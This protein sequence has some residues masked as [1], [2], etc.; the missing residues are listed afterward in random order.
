MKTLIACMVLAIGMSC[1]S[2][3]DRTTA[4]M[5][6]I[7]TN[8]SNLDIAMIFN[9]PS[10]VMSE[11]YELTLKLNQVDNDVYALEVS[12]LLNNDSQFVS[13]NSKRGFKG[14]FSIQIDDSNNLELVSDL[15]ETPLSVEEYDSHPFVDGFVNWVREDTRYNQKIKRT[16]E[17]K[18]HVMGMI[19]FVIE[20]RCTFEKI[21]III[22]YENGEMRVEIFQC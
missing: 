15:I 20:P 17:D 5:S 18:F 7:E 22:K 16:S 14:K 11:P 6:T 1:A 13:P 19:Q 4:Q 12:M 21:P 10:P 9:E 2:D 8:Q 3:K